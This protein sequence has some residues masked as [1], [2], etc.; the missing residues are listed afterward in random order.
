MGIKYNAC[1][2]CQTQ[3]DELGW[4]ILQPDLESHR[5][6]SAIFHQKYWEYQNTK[7]ASDRQG[8]KMITE[9][10][11]EPIIARPVL[12]IFWVL[13]HVEAYDLHWPDIL[14]NIYI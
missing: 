12:C 1:P 10:W 9:D 4:L 7:T 13:P 11:F 2:E 3:K 14:H 5:L 8:I 6:K